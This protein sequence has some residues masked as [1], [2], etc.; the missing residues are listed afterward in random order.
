MTQAL[1]L[2][3]GKTVI[4]VEVGTFYESCHVA[5]G[6]ANALFSSRCSLLRTTGEKN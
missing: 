6:G 2:A 1:P 3:L 4:R 5:F